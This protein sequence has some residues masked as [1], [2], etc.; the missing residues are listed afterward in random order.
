M[1]RSRPNFMALLTV[2]IESV[3]AVAGNYVLTCTSSVFLGKW[4]IY[5]LHVTRLSTL[6][7]LAQKFGTY[8]AN[9][10]W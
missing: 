10:E 7:R 4:G 2:S 1:Y 5:L 6:T 9:L 8:L 3:L